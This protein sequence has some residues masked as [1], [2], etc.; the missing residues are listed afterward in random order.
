VHK[1]IVFSKYLI[2]GLSFPMK[3]CSSFS[4][5]KLTQKSRLK[6]WGFNGCPSQK[7]C[8]QKWK[9][10]G[11]GPTHNP[12]LPSN[13][14]VVGKLPQMKLGQDWRNLHP[15]DPLNHH[16]NRGRGTVSQITWA[17]SKPWFTKW[18]KRIFI[19]YEGI[20]FGIPF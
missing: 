4:S 12:F 6:S 5:Q 20:L 13:K 17:L 18:G 7:P 10:P 2:I 15:L 9:P 3:C 1:Y 11:W 16:G 14:N 8:E 19:L